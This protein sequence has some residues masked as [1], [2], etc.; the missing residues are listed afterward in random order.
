MKALAHRNIIPYR[1]IAAAIL[2]AFV[3]A[4]CAGDDSMGAAGLDDDTG[5]ATEFTAAPDQVEEPAT[6]GEAGVGGGRPDAEA[7]LNQPLPPVDAHIIRDASLDVR[8]EDFDSAWVAVRRTAT[9]VGGYLSDASTEYE[10]IDGERYANGWATLHIPSQHF[11]AVLDDLTGLGERISQ[12][13]SGEDVTEEYVDLEARLAH[14]KRAEVFTLGLMDQA[15]TVEESLAIRER[16]DEIQ[17]TVEQIEGRLRYLDSRVSFSTIT[18]GITE[19]PVAVAPAPPV[20][21]SPITEA[22]QQAIEVLLAAV[23]FMIVAAA[24]TVPFAVVAA[25]AY[26]VWRIVRKVRT[27]RPAAE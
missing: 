1:T 10:E 12:S 27:P 11:D 24:F 16:L 7:V 14:W 20:E 15:E 5:G 4:A 17:L 25:L 13:I 18:V 21:P 2:A 9:S 19:V 3:L 6:A 23:S 22:F 8:V 26:G